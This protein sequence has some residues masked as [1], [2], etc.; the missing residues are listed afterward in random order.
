MFF[1]PGNRSRTVQQPPP[2][3]AAQAS[4]VERAYASVAHE[5]SRH[6]AAGRNEPALEEAIAAGAEKR[7]DRPR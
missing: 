1:F 7:G 6:R 4:A 5:K 3:A 2:A